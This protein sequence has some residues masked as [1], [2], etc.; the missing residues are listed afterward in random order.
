MPLIRKTKILDGL[1]EI[2]KR[3]QSAVAGT[4]RDCMTLGKC[5][6][7]DSPKLDNIIDDSGTQTCE[8][9]Y[10]NAHNA[11][12]VLG[13]DRPGHVNSGYGGRGDSHCASI[14]IVAGRMASKAK[15][16]VESSSGLYEQLYVNPDFKTDAARIYISQKTDVDRNFRLPQGSMP[17]ATTRSAIAM[18]ADGIR[19]IAREGI[20]LVSGAEEINSQGSKIST[21]VYGIDLIANND[22]SD[23]QPIPKGDNLQEAL[24]TLASNLDDLAGIVNSFL[25]SQMYY[26]TT[27]QLHTHN[28]PFFG[29]PVTLSPSLQISNPQ[30]NIDLVTKCTAG[31]YFHKVN[32]ALWRLS[33]L[34]PMGDNY[35]NSLYNNTN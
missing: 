4:S 5:D 12:I 8:I 31:L 34:S 35:I 21:A 10:S 11:S 2:K 1:S 18:K 19:I 25:I 27:V 7:G 32:M 20:K 6:T 22:D 26:N 15:T 16:G 30:T 14:D 23:L 33:N 13:R 28:S 29:I 9:I 17:Y 24:E 3:N